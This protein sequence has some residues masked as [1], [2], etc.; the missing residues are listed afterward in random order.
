M[1]AK[2]LAPKFGVILDVAVSVQFHCLDSQAKTEGA[3]KNG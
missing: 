1:G 2:Q 3:H